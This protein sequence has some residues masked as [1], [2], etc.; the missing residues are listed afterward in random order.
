MPANVPK[1][2]VKVSHPGETYGVDVTEIQG[3]SHLVLVDYHFCC[4]FERQLSS[5][6]QLRDH[7][8]IEIYICDVWCTRQTHQ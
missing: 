5:F 6:T 3:K 4:I 1:F 8:S 7:Q 2:K